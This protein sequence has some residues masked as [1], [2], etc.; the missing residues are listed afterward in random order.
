[1]SHAVPEPGLGR[2]PRRRVRVSW[3]SSGPIVLGAAGILA[4]LVLWQLYSLLGPVDP[5]H[6][7][8]P[9]I[10]LRQFFLNLT[11][12]QFWVAIGHT[13]WAWFLGL[14][15][16]AV[17]GFI[18]GLAIGSSRFLR[19]ATHSTIEFLRPIPSV[20]LIPLAALLFGPRI[21]SE[22]MIIVYACFW[23]VLIQVLYGIADIDKV[24]DDTVRTMRMGPKDRVK[25]LVFPTL[26]P[27]LVTGIRLTATVALILAISVELIVGT[28]GLGHEVAKAQINGSAPALI[29]LILTSGVFGISINAVMR[30]LERRVL[31]WHSSIRS[32]V[33]A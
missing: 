14:A 28:P 6:L 10:V 21:G 19:E 31:F 9:T 27:Y 5:E 23:I 22:L 30:F 3:S 24:A 20:G 11:Y 13:L 15:V 8:P 33:A 2:L 25:Y 17:A 16:S 26:L 12:V 7:P 32:E 1:M 29:A 18:A 4:S